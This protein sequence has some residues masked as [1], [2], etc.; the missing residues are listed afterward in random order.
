MINPVKCNFCPQEYCAEC[1]SDMVDMEKICLCDNKVVKVPQKNSV[2]QTN[3]VP[4]TNSVPQT[5]PVHVDDDDDFSELHETYSVDETML[6]NGNEDDFEAQLEYVKQL[7]LN[8]SRANPRENDT[9]DEELKLVLELSLNDKNGAGMS[10]GD[11]LSDDVLAEFKNMENGKKPKVCNSCQYS[12]G[13]IDSTYCNVHLF[14]SVC[15]KNAMEANPECVL[16]Q[17]D[18]LNV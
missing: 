6:S 4:Q 12:R 11:T 18:K 7:S 13:E 14:C 10:D 9:F 16:C 15:K 17:C 2:P 1:Y 3:P 8:E 5:N